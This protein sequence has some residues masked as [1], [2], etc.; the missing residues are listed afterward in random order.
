MND[1]TGVS[2]VGVDISNTQQRGTWLLQL[3]TPHKDYIILVEVLR[4]ELGI[5]RKFFDDETIVKIMHGARYDIQWLSDL[6]ISI[7][8]LFD[9]QQAGSV[10]RLSLKF[11]LNQYLKVDIDKTLPSADPLERP[12]PPEWIKYA[13]QESHYLPYLYEAMVA[14]LQKTPDGYPIMAKRYYR[15]KKKPTSHLKIKID[16]DRNKNI[17]FGSVIY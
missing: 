15:P 14:R 1:L 9:T 17:P 10:V 12:L 7:N 6:S 8:N 5:L 11:V 2:E 13:R 16:L 4:D 3:S